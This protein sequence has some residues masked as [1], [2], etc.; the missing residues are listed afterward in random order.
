MSILKEFAEYLFETGKQTVETT[1]KK[2]PNNP[3]KSLVITS[4]KYEVIDSPRQIPIRLELCHTVE[5]F[6]LCLEQRKF[7]LAPEVWHDECGAVAYSDDLLRRSSV[8]VK[9]EPH[10]ILADIRKLADGMSFVQK[11]LIRFLRLKLGGM[12]EPEIVSHFRQLQWDSVRRVKQNLQ[13]QSASLDQDVQASVKAADGEAPEQFPA[14]IPLFSDMRYQETQVGINIA[15]ELDTDNSKVILGLFPGTIEA[16]Q[17]RRREAVRG[18]LTV[19]DQDLFT[20]IAGSS[21]VAAPPV[22]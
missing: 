12:I 14:N 13:H 7:T 9:F 19:V 4:G 10:P 22:A 2:F 1:V 16:I 17:M 11:D 8:A 15:V 18:F 6:A 20:L 3:D 21:V 5:D